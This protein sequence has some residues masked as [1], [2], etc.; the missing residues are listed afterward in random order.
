MFDAQCNEDLGELA[1]VELLRAE[2][3]VARHL[4]G[5]RRAAWTLVAAGHDDVPAGARDAVPVHARVV[6]EIRILR[7]Q[8]RMLEQVGH[9]GNRHRDASRLAK[10]GNQLAVG[11]QHAQRHLHVVILQDRHRGESWCY[12]PIR[13]TDRDNCQKQ[14]RKGQDQCPAQQT[15][16]NSHGVG[17]RDLS[18][19]MAE[20]R[21]SSI[22]RMRRSWAN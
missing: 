1:R 18:Q 22:P 11:G 2:E 20:Y 5:D 13:H 19:N 10:A 7:R 9:I 21:C 16:E 15:L 14:T 6:I 4:L 12:K 17:K 8:H 3:E